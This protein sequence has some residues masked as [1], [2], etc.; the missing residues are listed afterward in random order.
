MAF[1]EVGYTC[2]SHVPP[3][4]A[5]VY[6]PS[7]AVADSFPSLAFLFHAFTLASVT[8]VP[9]EN[10]TV[11]VMVFDEDDTETYAQFD[12]PEQPAELQATM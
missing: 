2:N 10:S 4:T 1:A 5:R 9:S 7:D 11:P 12:C 3:D 8:G 6:D